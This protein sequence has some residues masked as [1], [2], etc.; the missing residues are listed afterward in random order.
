METYTHA[1]NQNLTPSVLHEGR[2]FLYFFQKARHDQTSG[3]IDMRA[4]T[5][6]SQKAPHMPVF[7]YRVIFFFEYHR[8][9]VVASHL[10]KNTVQ[11]KAEKG[12]RARGGKK[13]KE[14]KRS[15]AA[16]HDLLFS[17]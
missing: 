8:I 1:I 6:Q 13:K 3:Y 7:K 11:N 17:C 2:L 10:K 14:R 16:V 9:V 4:R 5:L 15:A 12:E